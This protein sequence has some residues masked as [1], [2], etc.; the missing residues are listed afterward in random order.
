M[1]TSF[2]REV[3]TLVP[4]LANPV[5]VKKDKIRSLQFIFSINLVL[6]DTT[7]PGSWGVAQNVFRFTFSSDEAHK[8]NSNSVEPIVD[9]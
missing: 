9:V 3:K 5:V 6:Q 1:K 2:G 4:R 7:Y 8:F